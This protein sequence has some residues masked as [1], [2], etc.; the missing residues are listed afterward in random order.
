MKL[1]VYERKNQKNKLNIP[2]NYKNKEYSQIIRKLE[3]K[4]SLQARKKGVQY[5]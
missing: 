5:F 4:N 3:E 1:S 2:I